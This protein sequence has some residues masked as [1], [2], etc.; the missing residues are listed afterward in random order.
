M[1]GDGPGRVKVTFQSPSG[2]TWP[3]V[4][5]VL[6]RVRR[7]FSG[8]GGGGDRVVG[9]NQLELNVPPA[10]VSHV[11]HQDC[12]GQNLDLALLHVSDVLCR[13]NWYPESNQPVTLAGQPMATIAE[14]HPEV[15][16][17]PDSVIGWPAIVNGCLSKPLKSP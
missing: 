17:S 10:R 13:S 8:G 16:Y 12:A 4:L 1:G 11:V 6:V 2:G 5:R 15:P 7:G 9:V 3:S 14:R